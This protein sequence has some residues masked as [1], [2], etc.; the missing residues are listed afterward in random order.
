MARAWSNKVHL[1]ADPH[2][3]PLSFVV[4]PGQSGDSPQ[5]RAVLDKIKVR[6]PVGRPASR[7]KA[8]AADKGL[9]VPGQSFVPA[10]TGNQERDPDQGG[11]GGEPQA[12][13]VA[14]RTSTPSIPS[15]T[16]TGTRASA[17]STSSNPGEASPLGRVFK[18]ASG[19]AA[20]SDA[21]AS[22][23]PGR[24]HTGRTWTIRQRRERAWQAPQPRRCFEDTA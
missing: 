3:R 2:C 11:P 5:F 23:A 24:P 12:T 21:C 4:T 22:K 19:Q 6:G 15:C 1:S 9:L 10:Q 8:V 13:R 16:R 17:A 14:R 20:A 18:G 7:P